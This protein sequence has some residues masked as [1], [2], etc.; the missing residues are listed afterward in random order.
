MRGRSWPSFLLVVCSVLFGSIIQQSIIAS[1]RGRRWRRAARLLS[2]THLRLLECNEAQQVDTRDPADLDEDHH[3]VAAMTAT[4]DRARSPQV[5]L[6]LSELTPRCAARAGPGRGCHLLAE[7]GE[8]HACNRVTVEH[9]HE[10]HPRSAEAFGPYP[11]R[12]VTERDKGARRCLDEAGGAADVH[13]RVFPQRPADLVDQLPVDPAG[14][15]AP[16]FRLRAGEREAD[17]DLT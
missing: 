10:L 15:P 3:D 6:E 2:L 4:S 8:E 16:S 5:D 9:V 7:G 1:G 14:V 13:Q 12:L 11:V 17:V